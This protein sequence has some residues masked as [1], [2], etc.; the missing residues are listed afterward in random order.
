MIQLASDAGNAAGLVFFLFDLLHLDGEDLG[1]RPLTERKVR[2]AGL[3]ERA[4]SSLHYSDHQT[5]L[6][7]TFMRRP[8]PWRSRGSSRNAPTRR[9]CPAIAASGSRSN[10]STA[11][12]SWSS[13][14][15]IPRV[16]DH[17]SVPCCSAITIPAESSPMPAAPA[18]AS[19]RLS[20]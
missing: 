16:R 15:P 6:G 20:S 18:P 17:F 8:A 5:G 1:A 7:P 4:S 10:A 14:G 3:L 12:N 19:T 11:R 9:T 2:L 13:A